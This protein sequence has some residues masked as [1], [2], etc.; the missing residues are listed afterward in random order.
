M[1]KTFTLLVAV[2]L[3]AVV[4]CG[5]SESQRRAEQAAAEAEKAGQTAAK[6]AEAAGQE[7]AKGMEGFAKAME[8]MAGALAGGG[9]KTVE[10]VPFQTLVGMMPTVDGWERETPR[11]ERMT[12][13]IPYSEAEARYTKGDASVEIK[14]VDSGFATMLIAP[15]SMMLASGYSRESSEGYEKA[16]TVLGHPGFEKWDTG[17]KDGELN[18]LVNKRFLVTLDGDNLSDTKVLHELAGRLDIGKLADLK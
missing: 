13:P 16:V 2:S 7:V 11:G 5:Q 1:Q 8:G 12:S 6:A 17:S 18:L 3:V 4:G 15:W 14:V 10:P 9:G